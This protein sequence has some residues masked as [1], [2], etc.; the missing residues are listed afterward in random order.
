MSEVFRNLVV[1]GSVCFVLVGCDASPQRTLSTDVASSAM[2]SD[3]GAPPTHDT[4]KREA[5]MLPE[6]S[7][8][9]LGPISSLKGHTWS[10]GYDPV[11]DKQDQP[12]SETREFEPHEIVVTLPT[13]RAI[14][15]ISKA[16]F[17]MQKRGIVDR[18]SLM[19]HA[20]LLRYQDAINLLEFILQEWD[21]ELSESSKKSVSEWKTEG[22]LQPWEIAQRR[23]GAELHGEKRVGIA[24]EIRPSKTGWYVV[25]D[26]AATLE[27]ERTLWDSSHA[28]TSGEIR[29][30]K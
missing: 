14:R 4:H 3:A 12:V 17:F 7:V 11:H 8:R 9:M 10:R 24:F 28:S 26:V 21:A 15:H 2:S 22:D 13:G 6:I 5:S 20:G 30:A 16:T 19:P 1:V 29:K 27:E 18:V 25:I 23:G